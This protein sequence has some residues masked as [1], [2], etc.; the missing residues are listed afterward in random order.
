MSAMTTTFWQ[1]Y[2]SD[3]AERGEYSVYRPKR[4]SDAGRDAL[5]ALFSDGDPLLS[6]PLLSERLQGF[7]ELAFHGLVDTSLQVTE[8]GLKA[9]ERIAA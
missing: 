4:L 8:R 5:R 1:A 7:I 3:A 2:L 9:A 6:A